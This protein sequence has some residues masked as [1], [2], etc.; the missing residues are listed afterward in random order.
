MVPVGWTDR[1]PAGAATPLTYEVLVD[2]AE[3][4]SAI[5]AR[6]GR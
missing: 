4:V 1:G 2:L 3:V 5:A 6:H